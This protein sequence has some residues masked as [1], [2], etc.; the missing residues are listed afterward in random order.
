MPEEHAEFRRNQIVAAAWDCFT[1]N[2]YH[3]TTLRDIARRMNTS[4]GVIY[5][6]F[7]GKDQ[8]LEAVNRCGQEGTAHFLDLA[9]SMETSREAIAELLRIYGE[10]MSETDRVQNARGAIAL[11]AEALK[12]KNYRRICESQQG[13]VFDQLTRLISRGV[14]A[15]EFK[16]TLDPEAFAGFL[17]ALLTGLQ[18]QSVLFPGLD[19]SAYYQNVQQILLQNIW[20]DDSQSSVPRRKDP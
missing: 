1:E 14:A 7:K 12:R 9:T 17:L 2:G 4:T 5:R 19:T 8:I 18:V 15:G 11:W 10:E 13:P 6:Y 16:V 20:K 3:E